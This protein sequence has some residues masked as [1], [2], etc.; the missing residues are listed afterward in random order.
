[1]KQSVGFH[2]F[3]ALP[4]YSILTQYVPYAYAM[5]YVLRFNVY[6]TLLSERLIDDGLFF[7]VV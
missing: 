2:Y 7:F 6:C 3:F 4:R 1:M 5:K